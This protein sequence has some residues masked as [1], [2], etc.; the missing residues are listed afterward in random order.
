MTALV[1]MGVSGCGKSTVG[2]LLAARLGM[3][4]LDADDLHSPEAKALMASGTPLNDEDRRPWFQRVGRHMASAA[5][6]AGI[7]VAC[8]ALKRSYRD[9]I[10]GESASAVFLH[11]DGVEELLAERVAARAGHFMPPGLLASQ[12]ATLEPL[13][14]DELGVT[15]SIDQPY[16]ALVDQAEDWVTQRD[17]SD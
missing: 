7:V 10:R 16:E 9:L 1:V 8:S 13:Q 11:L 6:E 2:S 5:S 15:L 4:F 3:E 14:A 12:L 17:E